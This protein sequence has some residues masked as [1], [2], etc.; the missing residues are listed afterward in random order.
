MLG[1]NFNKSFSELLVFDEIAHYCCVE[2]IGN[3]VS[4]RIEII[5]DRTLLICFREKRPVRVKKHSAPFGAF[6]V[7]AIEADISCVRV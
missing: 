4:V 1:V 7:F 5:A 2:R 6:F 3:T